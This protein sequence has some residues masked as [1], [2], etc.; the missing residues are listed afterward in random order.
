MDSQFL[1][2]VAALALVCWGCNAFAE[3]LRYCQRPVEPSAQEQDRLMQV[4]ALVKSELDRSGHSLALVARSGLALDW[5]G[6]RYS[7]AGV[8]LK[9]SRNAAWSV[10]QLYYACDE[11]R[12]QLFDQGMSG[13]VMGSRDPSLGFISI[14]FL[15]ADAALALES[16]ALDNGEALRWLGM[17]YSA[18]AY[19]F[20]QRYQNCN[21]WLAELLAA[22]WGEAPTDVDGRA[23]AQQWLA[24]QDFQPSVV[25]LAWQPLVW[26]AAALPWIHTDDHPEADLAF[27]QFRISMPASIEAFVHMRYPQATRIE[28]CYSEAQVVVHRGWQSL[29]A[30]CQPEATDEVIELHSAKKSSWQ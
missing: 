12:P 22:A 28:L 13:F 20:S 11:Q 19:A 25:R 16:T 10:R 18:N 27:A 4:A 3:S 17:E 14:V 23:W 1:R 15:P 30:N 9:A 29:A 21:Q 24:L 6:Y 5:L 7:H 8:S 2:G 26:L